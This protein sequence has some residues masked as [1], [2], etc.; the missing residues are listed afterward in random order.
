VEIT[1]RSASWGKEGSLEQPNSTAC[2]FRH[3][4]DI[5]ASVTVPSHGPGH[6]GHT[7]ET[8]QPSSL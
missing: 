5:P 1:S 7:R 8:S 3:V 2:S 4:R 6:T